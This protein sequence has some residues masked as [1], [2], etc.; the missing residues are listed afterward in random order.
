[1]TASWADA[2]AD[3]KSLVFDIVDDGVSEGAESFQ[4]TLS[5]PSGAAISGTATAVVNIAASTAVNNPPIARR[6]GGVLG[7][8][9]LGMLGLLAALFGINRRGG[10]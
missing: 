9:W 2:D 10:V 5:N 6:G 7:L 3:P 4:V 1:G 8:A